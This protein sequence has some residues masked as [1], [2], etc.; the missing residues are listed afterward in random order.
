MPNPFPQRTER[1][2]NMGWVTVLFE[3]R[4][5]SRRAA[6]RGINSRIGPDSW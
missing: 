5:V 6:G 3:L 4:R 1:M 2:R